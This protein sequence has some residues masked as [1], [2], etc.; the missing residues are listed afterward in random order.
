MSLKLSLRYT[1]ELSVGD[2]VLVQ[3]QD[4][5]T[6]TEILNVSKCNM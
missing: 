5:F 4:Q 3:E 2:Q 6:P 1:D